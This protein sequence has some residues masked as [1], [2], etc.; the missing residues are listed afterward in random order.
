MKFIYIKYCLKVIALWWISY[1]GCITNYNL[2]KLN[3]L[4]VCPSTL[5]QILILIYINRLKVR[6][7]KYYGHYTKSTFIY[8]NV[9]FDL[10][11]NLAEKVNLFT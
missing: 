6:E 7:N 10:V 8:L 5:L 4:E 1:F 3:R 2:K 9:N 11:Y